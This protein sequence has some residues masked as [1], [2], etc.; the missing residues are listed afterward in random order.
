M[1]NAK[2]AQ[3]TVVELRNAMSTIRS[4]DIAEIQIEMLELILGH[5]VTD[6]SMAIELVDQLA[7]MNESLKKKIEEL[8]SKLV[9]PTTKRGQP[10][11]SSKIKNK[12]EELESKLVKPTT[13][14]GQPKLS[15]KS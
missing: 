14:R 12:I 13:K 4:T 2:N 6:L 9:K 1:Y 7:Q 8:E 3:K 15:S 11:L 5:G 10:K